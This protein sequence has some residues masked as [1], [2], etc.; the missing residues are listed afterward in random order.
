MEKKGR[1]QGLKGHI[2][3]EKN[4]LGRAQQGKDM[5]DT[6]LE[7]QEGMWHDL[8]AMALG[9]KWDTVS[10]EKDQQDLIIKD[11]RLQTEEGC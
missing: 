7:R 6:N 2:E 9:S 4:R 3:F 10:D 11:L 5:T 1:K 8:E